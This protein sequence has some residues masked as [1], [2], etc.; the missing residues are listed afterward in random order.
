MCNRRDQNGKFTAY[1]NGNITLGFDMP[2]KTG[3]T[4]PK[5]VPVQFVLNSGAAAKD[6]TLR[7]GREYYENPVDSLQRVD[8][9]GEGYEACNN[10]NNNCGHI[11]GGG[12]SLA[13]AARGAQPPPR[14]RA[15][16][17]PQPRHWPQPQPGP[18]RRPWN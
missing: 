2:N 5:E 15:Q 16:H 10:C 9:K 11:P 13:R 3:C 7:L 8:E 1:G 14:P 17:R 6:K 12:T 4:W 18:P